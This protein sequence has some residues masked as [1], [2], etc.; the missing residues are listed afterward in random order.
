M[1]DNVKNLMQKW[2]NVLESKQVAPI[3]DSLRQ[4]TMAILLEN[5]NKSD[6]TSVRKDNLSLTTLMEDAMP[7]NAMGASSS[8]A[9]TGAIDIWDPVMI[10]MVRRTMPNL[11]AYDLV[12]V[13]PMT[14]PTGVVFA[15]RARYDNQNGKEALFYE[16]N[17]SHSGSY[18]G[19]TASVTLQVGD[20]PVSIITSGLGAY[21]V[22]SGFTTAGL[23]SLGGSTATRFNEMALSVER[24]PVVAQGRG[25]RAEYSTELAQDLKAVHG[26]DAE[27]ELT[28]ILSTEILAEI[29]REII[30][31][32]YRSAKIGAQTGT[33]AAGYFDLN[34]DSNGRW[35]VEKFKGLMYQIAQESHV[36]NKETRQGRGNFILASSSVAEAL[37]MAGVLDVSPGLASNVN[38][39][40]DDTGNTLAGTVNGMKVYIDPYVPATSQFAVVGFKGDSPMASGIFYCPY[41]P[42]QLMRAVHTENF[43]PTIGF[44]T[45]YGLVAN[46]FATSAADGVVN[47]TNKNIYY[48]MFAVTNLM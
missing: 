29:N 10:S 6:Y 5:Q 31:K 13:Q 4:R 41:V 3:K 47:G 9:N 1:S 18:K 11:I 44:K 12:G 22:S 46:P 20:D 42:L 16:A 48:R 39:N 36:I 45:R 7:T 25:L 14:Q 27:T 37:N 2:S 30:R 34:V 35:L 17:T 23:E 19:N 24:I 32:I 26:L 40:V 33:A 28:N 43:Q 38:L 15:L 21:T 8:T